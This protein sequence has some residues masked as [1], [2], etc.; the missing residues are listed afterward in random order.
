MRTKWNNYMEAPLKE[1]LSECER[2]KK[3]DR[4]G[5]VNSSLRDKNSEDTDFQTQIKNFQDKIQLNAK[6]QQTWGFPINVTFISL[7]MLWEEV[8]NTQIHLCNEDDAEFSVFVYLQPYSHNVLSVWFYL[9]VLTKP[10]EKK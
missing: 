6:G 8:K 10:K 9:L 2:K 5:G 4:Q 1:I 7:P 3:S